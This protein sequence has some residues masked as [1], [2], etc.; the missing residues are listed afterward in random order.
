M[1]LRDSQ[2]KGKG[3]F[4]AVLEWAQEGKGGDAAGYRAGFIEMVRTAQ[5]LKPREG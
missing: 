3:S 2:F 5:S 4:G 1:L